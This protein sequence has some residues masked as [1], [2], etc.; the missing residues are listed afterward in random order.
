VPVVFQVKR[1][2]DLW[3]ASRRARADLTAA[4]GRGEQLALVP[5]LAW[6]GRQFARLARKRGIDKAASF[7]EGLGSPT[8][9]LSNIGVLPLPTSYGALTLRS[10]GFCAGAGFTNHFS[11]FVSTLNGVM[12]WSFVWMAPLIGDERAHRIMS[13]ART[14]LEAAVAA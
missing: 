5:Y 10:V 3:E 7:L 2:D 14:R 11:C 13:A 6:M 12:C 8:F 1:E 4:L 9:A